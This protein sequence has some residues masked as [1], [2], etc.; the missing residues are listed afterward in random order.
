MP[1]IALH[2]FPF[3]EALKSRVDGAVDSL[4]W[5]RGNQGRSVGLGDPKGTFS[6]KPLSDSVILWLEQVTGLD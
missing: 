3:L 6:L 4:I 2:A 5:W 1:C